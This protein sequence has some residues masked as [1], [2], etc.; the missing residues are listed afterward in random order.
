MG[1]F[2]FLFSF[3]FQFFSNRHEWILRWG[4]RERELLKFC[5]ILFIPLEKLSAVGERARNFEL[6]RNGSES[7]APL[8]VVSMDQMHCPPTPALLLN[9][10]TLVYCPT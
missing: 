3:L 8:R 7:G 5:F 9:S 10:G 6:G 4:G 2:K 1:T